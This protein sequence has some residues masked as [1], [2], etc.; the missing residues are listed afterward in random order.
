V[1]WIRLTGETLSVRLRASSRVRGRITA[2]TLKSLRLGRGTRTL[3]LRVTLGSTRFGLPARTWRVVR[4]KLRAEARRLLAGH[5][6]VRASITVTVSA[7]GR[8][9]T[10]LTRVIVATVRR[11]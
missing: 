8:R 10:T 2:A 7:P 3:R 5:D 9:A 4:L 11:R 1:Q 6:T